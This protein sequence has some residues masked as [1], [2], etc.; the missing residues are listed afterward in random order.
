MKT[1]A[2]KILIVFLAFSGQVLALAPE[3]AL[4]RLMEGNKRFV[5]EKMLHKNKSQE[6]RETVQSQQ[7]PFAVIVACSDSRVAPEILFDEGIGDLFVVRVAGNVI[8]DLELE[9]IEY[10]VIVLKASL[11]VLLGHES[12]GAIKAVL[13]EQT[14]DIPAIAKI[15]KASFSGSPDLK[16]AI[17][18]NVLHGVELISQNKALA[19]LIKGRQLL[20]QG[21]YYNLN[22]GQ[23]DLVRFGQI[24]GESK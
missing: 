22:S 5:E 6:R 20:V 15:V 10:G 3:T 9:S 12:C 16:Q 14:Q 4:N 7:N 11:V 8:G 23:V 21:A 18:A 13:S 1:Y 17:E 2:L 19:P 24:E